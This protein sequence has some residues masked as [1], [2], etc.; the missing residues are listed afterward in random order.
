MDEDAEVDYDEDGYMDEDTP[1]WPTPHEVKADDVANG[2]VDMQG[3]DWSNSRIQLSREELH[4]QRIKGYQNYKNLATPH[5]VIEKEIRRNRTDGEF[6]RF[7][8]T[9]MD[10]KCSYVHFQL[11][12]LVWA[13]SKNDVFYT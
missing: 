11:R 8:Y 9:N 7:A 3:I 4:V 12:N 5:D 13:T 6:Y 2:S 1:G 10:V